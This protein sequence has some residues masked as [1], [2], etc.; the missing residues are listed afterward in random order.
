MVRRVKPRM[1]GWL[2]WYK[3]PGLLASGMDQVAVLRAG[4]GPAKQSGREM[5]CHRTSGKWAAVS[6]LTNLRVLF[7]FRFPLVI[8]LIFSSRF[9]SFDLFFY[10]ATMQIVSLRESLLRRD[11]CRCARV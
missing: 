2:A 10:E 11:R 1:N 8:S 6:S 4:L 5:R 9:R 3:V 7:L